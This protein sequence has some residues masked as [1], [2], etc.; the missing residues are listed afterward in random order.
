MSCRNFLASALM[1]GPTPVAVAIAECERQLAALEWRPPGPIGLRVSLGSLVAQSGQPDAGRRLMLEAYEDCRRMG[2]PSVFAI[3][4]LAGLE[5]MI[6]NL[7]DAES[8]FRET[9]ELLEVQG[10][11]GGL[12]WA[13]AELACV[14]AT[15]DPE[16]AER[17]AR[18]ARRHAADDDFATQVGW[19]RALWR[20]EGTRPFLDE[21][22]QLC[23]ESD[24][25]N[26]HAA[27]LEDLAAACG[28][29]GDRQRERAALAGAL[30]LYEAKGNALAAARIRPALA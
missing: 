21:A 14:V 5:L 4:Q 26:L 2:D 18:S 20:V 30:E 1:V 25:L 6:G 10:D 3:H 29:T 23:A 28:A 8:W 24:F 27:T 11:R 22:E 9:C 13:R 15:R 16:E 12:P 7:V 17:L 19:R